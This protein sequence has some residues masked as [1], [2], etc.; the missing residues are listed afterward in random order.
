MKD[1]ISLP[2]ESPGP[3]IDSKYRM[4]V[5]AA[6][7]AVQ[8][9]KGS[10]PRI[11]TPYHKATTIALVE[12]QEGLV[13]FVLGDEAVDARNKDEELYRQLLSDARAA[14]VDEEGNPIFHSGPP[15]SQ[16][17]PARLTKPTEAAAPAEKK[18]APPP[19]DG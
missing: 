2:L 11:Q 7:R 18:A 8:I 19:K 13:P 10:Q 3:G 4:S 1:I 14:C 17:V 12:A 6:Q 15:H 16:D 9:I 5:L